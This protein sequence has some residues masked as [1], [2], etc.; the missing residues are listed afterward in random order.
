LTDEEFTLMRLNVA[1]C[2]ALLISHFDVQGARQSARDAAAHEAVARARRPLNLTLPDGDVQAVSVGIDPVARLAT[3]DDWMRLY[4]DL[5]AERQ[6]RQRTNRMIGKVLDDR[7]IEDRNISLLAS[8]SSSISLRWQQGK[9]LG[10]GSYGSVYMAINFD[11]GDVMAVKEIRFQDVSSLEALKRTIKEEMTVMQM[12]HHPNIVAY[13][14]VEV[15]RDKLYIFMEYC[16]NSLSSL[17]EHG[18]IEDEMVIRIYTKQMLNGLE[19]LHSNNIVHRD[20]KPANTLIDAHGSIKF[21]DFG[22]SKIYRNQ[23]T[24]ALDGD[25]A[26]LIG[27]P[28]YMVR[29]ELVWF[30]K[31]GLTRK[32]SP[33][34]IT[35][36]VVNL[37]QG[38]QDIWS[39]GCCVLEMVTGKKPWA[40]LDNEWAIMYHIGIS[41]KA[42]PLPDTSQLSQEGIDFLTECF[43]RPAKDRPSAHD[44]LQHPWIKD[45]DENQLLLAE[46]LAS[47]SIDPYWSVSSPI[48]TTPN[49]TTPSPSIFTSGSSS[50]TGSLLRERRLHTPLP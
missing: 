25:N 7:N 6:R 35:G 29:Y 8:A 47:P 1:R 46:P 30:L 27:T 34:V 37:K 38:A 20:V 19:Y 36:E 10:G 26:S 14:G 50:T 33:E 13:Y 41:N 15:H 2:M 39:L 5:E 43:I 21:V 23:K 18:R 48:V 31:G 16:P 12:L 28:H 24:I 3:R 9:F 22:A 17:L 40:H 44:L 4:E 45:V 42:P 32:Q 49:M 11:S